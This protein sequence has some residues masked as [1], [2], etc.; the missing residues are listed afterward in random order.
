MEHQTPLRAMNSNFYASQRNCEIDGLNYKIVYKKGN[1]NRAVD[2]LSTREVYE[3]EELCM[4][5]SA[6]VPVRM[7]E[8]QQSY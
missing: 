7:Q 5:A 8:I 4:T 1:E 6:V 2:A 3:G